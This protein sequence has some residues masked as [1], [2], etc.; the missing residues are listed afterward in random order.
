MGRKQVSAELKG[1]DKLSFSMRPIENGYQSTTNF[2]IGL[3]TGAIG[4]V[5]T[6]GQQASVKF[7]QIS[8]ELE[9]GSRN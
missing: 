2:D 7:D 5:Q 6:V 8:R 9:A 4:A 1:Q 3:I